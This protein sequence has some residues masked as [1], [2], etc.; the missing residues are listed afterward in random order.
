MLANWNYSRPLL[1]LS[2]LAL[3]WLTFTAC[4]GVSETQLS[5]AAPVAIKPSPTSPAIPTSTLPPSPPSG[6]SS[7]MADSARLARPPLPDD[8]TQADYGAQIY[9]ESCMACHGDQGQGLTDEWRAAWAAEDRNCWQS[10]CHAANHPDEGFKLPRSIPPVI[11]QG[12]LARFQTA[13]ELQM[14]LKTSMPWQAPGLFDETAYWQLTAFLLRANDLTPEDE[15][16][17]PENAARI[18]LTRK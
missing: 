4:R 12:A 11:G 17:G 6:F 2:L 10:K 5:T 16:I 9:Y 1:R 3:L 15:S 14:F 13:A 8:P 18:S 7:N